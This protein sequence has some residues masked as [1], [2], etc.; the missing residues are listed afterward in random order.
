M[1]GPELSEKEAWCLDCKL[2]VD[3]ADK[4]HYDHHVI[5]AKAKEANESSR[6]IEA[7]EHKG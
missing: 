5:S 2:W 6:N 4:E 7:T 3:W 1:N